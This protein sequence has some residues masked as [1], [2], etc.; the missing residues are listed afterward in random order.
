[1]FITLT[2]IKYLNDD[3]KQYASPNRMRFNVNHITRYFYDGEVKVNIIHSK[4]QPGVFVVT[5]TLEEIDALLTGGNPKTVKVL[6]G[7]K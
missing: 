4:N 7:K 6:F 3:W 2:A 1:M 5:E